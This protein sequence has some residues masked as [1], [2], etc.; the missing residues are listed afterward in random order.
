[1]AKFTYIQK[2]TR[3]ITKLLKEPNIKIAFT[4]K[5]NIR[6]FYQN[7]TIPNRINTTEVVYTN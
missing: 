2:E 1:L 7:I 4:T 6:N 3:S 5:N